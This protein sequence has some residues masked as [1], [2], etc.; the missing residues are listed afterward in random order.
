LVQ[1]AC[2][3]FVDLLSV[4]TGFLSMTLVPFLTGR[5]PDITIVPINISYD[6]TLEEVLFAYELL[7]VPK[8]KESTS[9][10]CF[11]LLV[12][13]YRSACTLVKLSAVCHCKHFS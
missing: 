9:V 2:L 13:V 1:D 6:R 3:G 7:G 11:M 8:P 4:V 5:V 10:S 12:T